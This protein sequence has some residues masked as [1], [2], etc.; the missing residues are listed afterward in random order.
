MLVWV[1]SGTRDIVAKTKCLEVTKEV[2]LVTGQAEYIVSGVNYYS[3]LGLVYKDP[4]GLYSDPSKTRKGM[5]LGNPWSA[6]HTRDKEPTYWYEFGKN[7]FGVYPALSTVSGE[8]VILYM[9]TRPTDVTSS[10][11]VLVPAIYENALTQYVAAKIAARNK[12][13]GSYQAFMSAYDK[14][15]ELYSKEYDS[16]YKLPEVAVQ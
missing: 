8:S 7:G 1:N 11:E 14:E 3:I 5:T 2:S 15:L 6:G 10:A 4:D 12:Q 13:M 16:R 9:V